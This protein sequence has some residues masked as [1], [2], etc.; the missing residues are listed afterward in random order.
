MAQ[1]I[2]RP[3]R[4][5]RYIATLFVVTALTSTGCKGMVM[6]QGSTPAASADVQPGPLTEWPL[7]FRGHNFGIATYALQEY[8]VVYANRPYSG[9]PRPAREDVHPNS[10][11]ATGAGHL[12]IRNFPRPAVVKWTS[13]DGTPLEAEV[14]IG[15]IFKDELVRYDAPRE[16]ISDRTPAINPDI[17]LEINDRTIN[18]YMRAFL[19]LKAP[20]TP[21][22][23]HSNFRRD[24]VLAWSE[25][26]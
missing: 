18:V 21:G 25:T 3:D 9:G 19:S 7:R 20:R 6:T 4:S 2:G 8:T 17:V 1:G 11:N 22:N 5:A 10:L 23:P 26:Y 24:L 16:E 15:R 12:M 14:D 13:R